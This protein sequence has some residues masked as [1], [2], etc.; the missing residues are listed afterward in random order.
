MLEAMVDELDVEARPAECAAA[1]AEPPRRFDEVALLIQGDDNYGVGRVAREIA[2]LIPGI[3]CV[4]F[5]RGSEY[6]DIVAA[7]VPVYVLPGGDYFRGFAPRRGA[8]AAALQLWRAR[9]H[10]RHCARELHA[11]CE[12]EGVRVLHGNV[13]AHYFTLGALRREFPGR[14]RTIWHTHNF[15]NV[16]RHLGLRSRFNWWQVRRGADWL[17][18]VSDSVADG[19]GRS[20]VPVRVVHNAVSTRHLHLPAAPMFSERV[21]HAPLR[22]VGAG[23][24]EWSKGHHVSLA[25][26][27]QLRAAGIPATL[28]L[29][30]G[31]LEDNPYYDELRV[32]AA[33]HQV[34]AYVRFRGF[35]PNLVTRLADFDLALQSRIDPEPCG[36]YVLECMHRGLPMIASAGGGTPELV[37]DGQEG[38]LYPPGDSVALARGVERLLSH[39][40]L[41]DQLGRSARARIGAEF[42]PGHFARKLSAFYADVLASAP[43][44]HGAAARTGPG[45]EA[46]EGAR[47]PV[48]S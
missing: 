11:W 32:R 38:I 28:D 17:L 37:R 27:V 1:S 19:W 16:E 3:R 26:L 5:S 36:L 7:G 31:P 8:V 42:S 25:A 45:P 10:W 34:D 39:P 4:A 23:R 35:A 20:G 22:L 33:E 48:T 47:G 41:A 43:A 14:Y 24:M 13:W 6:D 46:F 30:G 18:A 2:A 15:L 44:T 12:R 29:F 9:A 40:A 21:R